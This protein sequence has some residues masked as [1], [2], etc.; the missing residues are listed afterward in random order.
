M[1]SLQVACPIKYCYFVFEFWV[2]QRQIEPVSLR[3]LH[4]LPIDW[5][6]QHKIATLAFK[7]RL[8]AT[9]HYLCN[10]IFVYIP[11]LLLRSPVSSLL[12][13]PSHKLTFGS[14][15]S[16]VAAPTIWNSL[17][18]N[19]RLSESLTIF[20]KRLKTHFFNCAYP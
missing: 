16:R 20:R 1:K 19:I 4:W 12:T 14:R 9:P 3:R 18:E 13:A 11:D 15:A 17:P 5:R 6:I 8:A 7:A 2:T 10:L